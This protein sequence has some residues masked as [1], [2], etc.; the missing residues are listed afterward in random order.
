MLIYNEVNESF[1]DSSVGKELPAMQETPVPL[2]SQ[3][4]LLE[5]DRLPTPVFLGFPCGS[6]GK[7]STCD[8][9]DLGLIPGLGISAGESKGYPLQSSGLENS[10]DCIVLGVTESQTR[11]SYF[12]CHQQDKGSP[13]ILVSSSGCIY[14]DIL[15]TCYV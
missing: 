2:L 9:G 14:S 11:L 1:P 3:E 12:H 13:H 10:M 15:L 7:E 8:V 6:A 4:D 5:R